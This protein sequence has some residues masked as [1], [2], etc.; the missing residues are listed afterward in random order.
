MVASLHLDAGL[1]LVQIEGLGQV[2]VGAGLQKGNLVGGGDARRDDDDGQRAIGAA[3]GAHDL[4]AGH[5]GQHEIG[6]NDVRALLAQKQE[7]LGAREGLAAPVAATLQMR[8][9]HLVDRGVV[10]DDEY[11]GDGFHGKQDNTR[12]CVGV[13]IFKQS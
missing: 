6:D 5:A 11:V 3:D 4:L 9:D 8:A 7:T 12:G 1:Q 10:L 13:G 2:V